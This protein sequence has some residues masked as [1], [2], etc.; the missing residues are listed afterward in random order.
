MS[1][2]PI[3]TS[4]YHRAYGGYGHPL[5]LASVSLA[6]SS[7]SWTLFCALLYKKL[8]KT[9]LPKIYLKNNKRL[10]LSIIFGI[11]FLNTTILLLT[12]SKVVIIINFLIIFFVFT[13]F[14]LFSKVKIFQKLSFLLIFF[15]VFTSVLSVLQDNHTFKRLKHTY[16]NVKDL[17][18][19]GKED[20]RLKFWDVYIAMIKDR[21]VSGYGQFLIKKGIRNS[22]YDRL[23]YSKLSEKFNAHNNYL[24]LLADLGVLGSAMFISIMVFLFFRIRQTLLRESSYLYVFIVPFTIAFIANL[25]HAFTQNVFYDSSVTYIYLYFL[26]LLISSLTF[27][28]RDNKPKTTSFSKSKAHQKMGVHEQ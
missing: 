3:D 22:Y 14:T 5:T 10:T 16:Q 7:F 27:E 24:E 25:I 11:T 18:H 1:Y 23:G 17:G 13:F 2:L 4:K 8:N 21:W 20:N 12:M 9:L 19:P 28:N 6:Y 26:I 15:L